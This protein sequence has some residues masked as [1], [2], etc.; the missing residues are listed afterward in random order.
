MDVAEG[1]K[2][3]LK[4]F[5]V[6]VVKVADGKFEVTLKNVMD[7]EKAKALNGRCEKGSDKKMVVVQM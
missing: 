5:P 2:Q 3:N 7:C 6:K 1:L 4:I